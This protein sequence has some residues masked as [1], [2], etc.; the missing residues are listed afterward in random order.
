MFWGQVINLGLFL[1]LS[2]GGY[3]RLVTIPTIPFTGAN[4]TYSLSQL[5]SIV[6]DAR[7]ADAID[8]DGAT[9][10][11]PTLQQF[12]E[13]FQKDLQSTVGIDIPL[14]SSRTAAV[15]SIFF[16]LANETG[17]QDAAGR[18]TSEAYTL[19]INE[20]GVR[21][22]GA[23]PLGAWWGSRSL[24]QAAVVSGHTLPQGSAVDAPGWANRGV[25]L[26]A[27]RHFYPP[28]FLIEMCAFL[29]FF[30]QNVFHVH[31][32]DNLYNNVDRYSAQQ[33]MDLYAAFRLWSDDPAVAGLNK[34]ANESYTKEQFDNVQQ[35]CAR[36]GVTII[37]EIEAPGHALVISQWRPELAL[38]DL[39]MLN[40]THP[41]TIP[42][43]KAI[44]KTFLPWFHSKTV[45]IGAD[46]YDTDLVTDYTSFVNTMR[47]YIS[48]ESGKS[49]RIWGTFTPIQGA[50]VSTDVSIQH[51]EF[52]EDNPYFDYIKNGYNVLNSDD[53]FYIVGKWSGSYPSTLNKTRVFHGNPAGGAF[54][55]NVF[56]TKNVTNNPP[57]NDPH[58]L[59]HLAA[60]WNDYGPNSTTVLETYYSWRDTLPALADKQWGGN[61]LEEE[62]DAVFDKIHGAIPGQNLDRQVK[63]HTD[64]ILH[65][66]FDSD[67]ETVV[68]HSGNGYDGVMRGCHVQDSALVLSN[69]C[70]V[71]TPLGSKGRDYT[72]SF[73]VNPTSSNPGTLFA[74][75]DS[76][77][78]SGNG[79]ISNM[80]LISG[81]NPYSLNY[82]LPLD[83]W[84][85]VH[86][87]GKGNQTL[88]SVSDSG[89]G[90][91]RMEFLAR[92][93]INGES[94]VWAPIAI[95]APLA[96][97]GEGFNGMM[98]E[99]VL[100]GSAE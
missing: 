84:T 34:R 89:A 42:T 38:D 92:L 66:K 1:S 85:Q 13:T 62:Y 33:S 45:H 7:Y 29:S 26:D 40:I 44:W 68:D 67:T 41:D 16:T 47:D 53:A 31:L 55:P 4:D 52:F 10:I 80:T 90:S 88:L 75:P 17:F 49:M 23:S 12:A 70:Y 46:E 76:V 81:G 73:W 74:G 11:P 20:N 9:Q 43:M 22:S 77:L 99:V 15:N 18:Y 69:G 86:L 87:V 61:I 65:Y 83:T 97:I 25:M 27:G 5:T 93:G 30:K 100:R 14:T 28:E 54:A 36:R 95:E 8:N 37:P 50:N 63:S 32:S 56:D 19:T 94:Q 96:R 2:I 71:D 59:G 24:I 39:S 82:S 91:T 51:W 98:K 60:L 3:T 58:V 79:S 64:T 78:L 72:L 35:Q 48:R 6:V 21:I 57:R